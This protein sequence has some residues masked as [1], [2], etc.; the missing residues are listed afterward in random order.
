MGIP[1]FVSSVFIIIE[2]SSVSGCFF[3]SA[4]VYVKKS[5]LLPGPKGGVVFLPWNAY[6]KIQC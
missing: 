1:I 4:I 2:N 6:D 5:A 3:F